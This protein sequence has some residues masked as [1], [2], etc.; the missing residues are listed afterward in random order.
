MDSIRR[1]LEEA[2]TRRKRLVRSLE[3]TDD[4]DG[5]LARDVGIRLSELRAEADELTAA[6]RT[7]EQSQDPTPTPELLDALPVTGPDLAR[8]SD[9]RARVL[10]DAFRLEITYD[11]PTHT[12]RCRA[13]LTTDTLPRAV[14]AAAGDHAAIWVVPPTGF[15]PVLPP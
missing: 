3:F 12:A 10:F 4:P 13:T 11:K 8:V 7:L 1:R 14:A 15:E 9:E 5:E 2:A 6:L